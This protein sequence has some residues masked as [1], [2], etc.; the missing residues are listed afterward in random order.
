MQL[1][2]GKTV[3]LNRF[4][5]HSDYI[6]ATHILALKRLSNWVIDSG[7]GIEKSKNQK[8]KKSIK[9]TNI[10]IYKQKNEKIQY[11]Y[12]YKYINTY[13]YIYIERANR[14]RW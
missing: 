13:I 2:H 11:I 6:W 7:P 5:L 4:G 8:L 14:P 1:E 3:V 12:I 9:K 10:Y